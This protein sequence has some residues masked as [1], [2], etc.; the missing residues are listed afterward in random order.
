MG[1]FNKA[2][3]IICVP[4]LA[5]IVLTRTDIGPRIAT[6]AGPGVKPF[7]DQ[8]KAT[9][10]RGLEASKK[11]LEVSSSATVRPA[12]ATNSDGAASSSTTASSADDF[13]NS[14]EGEAFIKA[15]RSAEPDAVQKMIDAGRDAMATGATRDMA[16]DLVRAQ[17][18]QLA[19]KY[20]ALAPNETVLVFMREGIRLGTKAVEKDPLLCYAYFHPK[21]DNRAQLRSF[22]SSDDIAATDAFLAGAIEKGV[23][24]PTQVADAA[25]AQERIKR[26]LSNLQ[27]KYGADVALLAN[28]GAPDVDKAKVCVMTLD[29]MYE[30][31]AL[32]EAEAADVMRFLL[33]QSASAAP[34]AAAPATQTTQQTATAV[35]VAISEEELRALDAQLLQDASIQAIAA[36]EPERYRQLALDIAIMAKSGNS[37]GTR[38]AVNRVLM[39]TYQKYVPVAS[40]AAAIDMSRNTIAL[41]E[42]LAAVDPAHCVAFLRSQPIPADV[43]QQFQREQ[44]RVSSAYANVIKTGSQKPSAPVDAA[45]AEALRNRVREQLPPETLLALDAGPD[46]D[47][48]A[49]CAATTAFHKQIYRLPRGEAGAL[50]RFLS[51]QR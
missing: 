11:A 22:L 12:G 17:A 16:I 14:L 24:T 7:A 36:A 4:I 2:A 18:Q 26:V 41:T 44:R 28:A 45:L 35:P 34:A 21:G 27:A 43:M 40:D 3:I 5:G 31:S 1:L 37:A 33:Q 51:T 32:P 15:L 47:A 42:R 39:E 49:F 25:L 9:F 20:V 38:E 10:D 19:S 48:G 8:L 23:A 46:A 30:I 13:V 50:L 6:L 29:L